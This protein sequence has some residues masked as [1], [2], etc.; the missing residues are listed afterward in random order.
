MRCLINYARNHSGTPAIN[1]RRRSSSAAEGQGRRRD[2]C[3]FSHTACGRP[4][5]LYARRYGYTSASSWQWG[6]N[7]AW[8]RGKRGTPRQILK[9]WLNSPPH[10]ATMLRGSFNDAGVGL[11]RGGFSGNQNAS[12]W[13]LEVGCHGC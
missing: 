5:D 10:R 3:G 11:R 6:E 9:A 12:V 1:R 7:L 8:G 13:A 2:A 4:A